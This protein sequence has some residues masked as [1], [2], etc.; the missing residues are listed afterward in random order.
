MGRVGEPNE[1]AQAILFLA[2]DHARY[3]TGVEM[4]IDGGKSAG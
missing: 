3:I 4:A 2:S 1:I